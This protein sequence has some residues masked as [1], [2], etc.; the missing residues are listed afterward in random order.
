VKEECFFK[1]A[2]KAEGKGL[3][4]G[5]ATGTQA[6]PGLKNVWLFQNAG[7]FWSRLHC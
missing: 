2:V 7:G 6:V 5:H 4:Q 3:K 1:T